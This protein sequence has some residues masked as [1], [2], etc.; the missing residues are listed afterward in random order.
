M[1]PP[2]DSEHPASVPYRPVPQNE[3]PALEA[4]RGLLYHLLRDDEDQ[5]RLPVAELGR[6][7][8]RRNLLL[9]DYAR[10]SAH[11]H[12][13]VKAVF[14][15]YLV[16]SLGAHRR[17]QAWLELS[18]SPR[19]AEPV[20]VA[21]LTVLRE[22]LEATVRVFE[23]ERVPQADGDELP[24]YSAKIKRTGEPDEPWSVT[25]T[26][27]VKPLNVHTF[28][29]VQQIRDLYLPR[30]IFLV[31]IAAGIQEKFSPGDVVVPRKVFYYEPERLTA[32]GARPRP[33]HAE[34]EDLSLYGYAQHD[35]QAGEFVDKVR[36]FVAGLPAYQRPDIDL[37]ELRPKV[38]S[39]NQ[40][41]ACGERVL[42]DGKYLIGL[43]DFDETI[44]AADQESYGFVQAVGKRP[45]MIFRGIS[46]HADPVKRDDWKYVAAGAAAICLRDFLER[47]YQPKGLRKF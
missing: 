37:N 21:I 13:Q 1:T 7:A 45:W 33:E 11:L 27:T 9:A 12:P 26:H 17:S 23:A 8:L 42:R 35:P 46:D 19:V 29:P 15:A 6:R 41:I 18:K 14:D 31:G 47:S 36:E 34:Q 32:D 40:T 4:C 38:L 10:R 28:G 2:N 5:S 43:R 16:E 22:E 39:E 3:E 44:S 30:A 25:I 24:F 20:D